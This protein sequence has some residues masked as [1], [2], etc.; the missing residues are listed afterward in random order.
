MK[1]RGSRTVLIVVLLLMAMGGG[2]TAYIRFFLPASLAEEPPEPVLETST[3]TRGDIVITVQGSGELVPAAELELT[4]RTSGVLEDVLAEV[5][6]AVQEGD[7]LAALE[8]DS[9]ERAVAEAYIEVELAQLELADVQ[10]GPS[11][12]ELAS[13]QAALRDAQ[14]E[15]ELAQ[16]AYQSTFDSNL[17]AIIDSRKVDFDWW[18][19]YYQEQKG[20]YERGYLSQ[21]DHD[22]AMNAM[23][24]ADG[25]WQAAI[26]DALAEEIQ[27]RNRVDQAQNGVYKTQENLKLLESGPLADTV[28]RAILSVDQALLSREEASANLEAAQ[29]Y[30]PFDGIVMDVAAIGGQQVGTN[31]PILTLADLQEPLLRFWVEETDMGGVAVGRSVS[32]VFEAFPDDVF[33]GEIVRMDPVLVT[34]DGT[35]AVQTWASVDYSVREVDLLAGMTADVEVV[36][37]EARG[38]TLVP[39]EALRELSPGQYAV[40]VVEPNGKLEMRAVEVGL[41]DPINAEILDGL[42]LGETVSIGEME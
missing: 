24:S 37:A 23:I 17:D 18:V 36:A 41:R 35:P 39:V 15:L 2:Y 9:L 26:N 30:A 10:E 3:A 32:I 14:V 16:N 42:D 1:K 38:A 22:W 13:A 4:F 6:D 19:G 40:F 34:V 8:T 20:K 21:A 5:G 7:K 28:T 11:E 33:S 25:R 31:T 12:A 27:V 29:L